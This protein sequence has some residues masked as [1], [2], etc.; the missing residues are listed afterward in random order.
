MKISMVILCSKFY[1]DFANIMSRMEQSAEPGIYEFQNFR[2]QYFAV[3]S[4]ESS[5]LPMTY[6]VSSRFISYEQRIYW[7]FHMDAMSAG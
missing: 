2:N 4:G 1:S 6:L 5:C 3:F 7:G